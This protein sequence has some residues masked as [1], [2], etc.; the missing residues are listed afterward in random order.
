M[1]T[2]W[3]MFCRGPGDARSGG[4]LIRMNQAACAD[5]GGVGVGEGFRNFSRPCHWCRHRDVLVSPKHLLSVLLSVYLQW[6][7]KPVGCYS[8][9]CMSR[10]KSSF[11]CGRERGFCFFF[12][13]LVPTQAVWRLCWSLFCSTVVLIAAAAEPAKIARAFYYLCHSFP[14]G[15]HSWWFISLC[16]CQQ[17]ELR[18]QVFL[19][20]L[21]T[22]SNILMVWC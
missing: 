6:N 4:Y 5:N 22:P 19:P 11:L 9:T 17:S 20:K 16:W 13:F 1:A 21:P 2:V 3:K 7:P 12:F 18:G 8:F 15:Q 14:S 10:Y